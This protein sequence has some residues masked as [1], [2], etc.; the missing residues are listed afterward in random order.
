MT[1]NILSGDCPQAEN[2]QTHLVKAKQVHETSVDSD[3]MDQPAR[4][5]R[6]TLRAL[7]HNNHQDTCNF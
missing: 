7:P 4:I 3:K 1:K 5:H 2:T 6:S